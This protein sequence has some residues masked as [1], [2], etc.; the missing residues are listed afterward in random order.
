[1]GRAGFVS[2]QLYA[3]NVQA[4]SISKTLGG[5]GADTTSVLFGKIMNSVPKI[6]VQSTS[7]KVITRTYVSNKTLS[8]FTLNIVTSSLTSNVTFDYVAYDDTYN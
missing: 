6:V 4:G 5:T 2:G 1:M 8:G 7:N 3:Q